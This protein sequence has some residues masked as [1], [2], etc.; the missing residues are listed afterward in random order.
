MIDKTIH[1]RHLLHLSNVE[2]ILKKQ[3]IACQLLK[4]SEAIPL[5]ML[6]VGLGK[7]SNNKEQYLSCSFIPMSE[8]D[9][10]N[11]ALLQIY[12]EFLIDINQERID[13]VL[14]YLNAINLLQVL[15]HFGI[16]DNSELYYKYIFTFNQFS[17]VPEDQIL[18]VI[19]L[20]E[21][22]FN[23]FKQGIE[24][25]INGSI[26]LEKALKKFKN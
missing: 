4:A 26:T 13:N 6:L 23:A 15:G 3:K 14:A 12:S 8:G 5:N 21:Y 16:K 11:T 19:F 18:E 7:D 17:E 22:A 1:T 25:F 2:K 9:I 10:K 24:D 20:I